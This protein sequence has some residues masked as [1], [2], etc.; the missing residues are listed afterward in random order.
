MRTPVHDPDGK[1]SMGRTLILLA[2]AILTTGALYGNLELRRVGEEL[3]ALGIGWEGGKR[4]S[5]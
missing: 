3:L 4:V 2:V 1:V 5:K